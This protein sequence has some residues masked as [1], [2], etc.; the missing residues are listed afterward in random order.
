[1]SVYDDPVRLD[2]AAGLAAAYDRL[3]PWARDVLRLLV[4]RFGPLP[5]E[6]EELARPA[7]LAGL[8]GAHVRAGLRMLHSCGLVDLVPKAWREQQYRI[9]GDHLPYW[10]EKLFPRLE[11]EAEE[12]SPGAEGDRYEPGDAVKDVLQVLLAA[13]R[14]ELKLLKQGVLSARSVHRLEQ[15]LL[16]RREE[17]EAGMPAGAAVDQYGPAVAGALHMAAASGLLQ[18]AEGVLRPVEQ[19]AAAWAGKPYGVLSR[20]L[21]AIWKKAVVPGLRGWEFHALYAVEQ[22]APGRWYAM[23]DLFDWLRVCGMMDLDCM[24]QM[25][26]I[27]TRLVPLSAWGWLCLERRESGMAFMVP[28]PAAAWQENGCEPSFAGIIVQPDLEIIVPPYP[29]PALWQALLHWGEWTVRGDIS[30]FRLTPRSMGAGRT[31]G[32]S[33]EEL[34]R[35]LRDC[36]KVAI[37]D[38]VIRF[39]R[40]QGGGAAAASALLVKQPPGRVCY[41]E[42]IFGPEAGEAELFQSTARLPTEAVGVEPLPAEVPAAWWTL[43]GRGH[44]STEKEMVRRAISMKTALRMETAGGEVMVVPLRMVEEAEDW[45]LYGMLGRLEVRLKPREWTGL[46]LVWPGIHE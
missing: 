37:D 21:Y 13:S 29:P 46:R 10:Q 43:G 36:S 23:K 26:F 32:G 38:G 42:P 24:A 41:M 9:P 35:L 16:A 18:V 30:V 11:P 27:S 6:Q 44:P 33:A 31:A 12:R 40:E 22:A 20:E 34:I 15:A 39:I 28:A 7:L 45:E 19:A 8:S 2:M 5:A 17:L 3:R 14:G 4:A 25:D 1:M